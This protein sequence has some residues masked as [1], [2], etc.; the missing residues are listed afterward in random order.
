[1]NRFVLALIQLLAAHQRVDF[2][3]GERLMDEQRLGDGDDLVPVLLEDF[4]GLGV[5]IIGEALD[6]F[7]DDLRGLIGVVPVRDVALTRVGPGVTDEAEPLAHAPIEDHR[8]RDL[9]H[10]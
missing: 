6:L 7:V 1:M 8:A 9:C 4:R 10:L 2:V 5:R 3:G